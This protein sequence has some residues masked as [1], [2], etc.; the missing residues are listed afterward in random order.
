[1]DVERG[2]SLRIGTPRRI[3]DLPPNISWMAAMPDQQKFVA[4]VPERAG[5]G[6]VTVVQNWRAALEKKP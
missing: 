6:S 1:M 5:P 3:A 2:A 4:I